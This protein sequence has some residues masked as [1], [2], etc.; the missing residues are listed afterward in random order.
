MDPFVIVIFGATGDLAQN[1]LLPA[2]FSLYKQNKLGKQFFVI[3]FA[4][5]PFSDEEYRVLL[6][7]ELGY[8]K[9]KHWV[10]FAKNI[11]YQQGLFG[12]KEGYQEL[13]KKIKAFDKKADSDLIRLFYLATP[14]DNY[15]TIITLIKNT[16]L[17]G[18]KQKNITLAKLAIEKPFG[19]DSDTARD[20]D[21]KLSNMFEEKQ[22]FRVDH[23]LGKETVQNMIAFRFA[24]SIFEPIWNKEYI[25]HIQITLAEKKGIGKRGKSF[26][27]VGILRDVGQNHLLQLLAAVAME[28]PK[29]FTQEDVRDARANAIKS[30]RPIASGEIYKYVV[31]GQYK[32]YRKVDNVLPDSKTETFVAMKLFVDTDRF[33]GVPFYLRAGKKLA[34][35]SVDIKIVFRQTCSVFFKDADCPEIGNVLTIHIQPDEGINL[36]LV[37]KT[38][39][40]KLAL[41]SVDMSFSY[42]QE[43]GGHGAPA[44]EKVLQDIISGD[45]TLFNRSDEL[46]SSWQLISAILKGWEKEK[47]AESE[48]RQGR[49][50]I[51]IYE[52]GSWG[53]KAGKELIERDGR[54]WL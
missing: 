32:G 42:Q 39:G 20:L 34:E 7:N 6:G 16:K 14:S 19:K 23:Y 9:N 27:G 30:I 47:P 46:E 4:R 54:K 44:Y 40:T 22:I 5:R 37:A 49:Q 43:F 26:D 10:K 38:P 13:I 52:Q 51:A 21:K 48:A 31:R 24:N 28:Q 18:G 11:F 33:I 3:G 36:H 15:E 29:S 53:P 12:E 8:L 1:K 50:K 17:A 2:L 25:D 41:G 45:Q 35:N